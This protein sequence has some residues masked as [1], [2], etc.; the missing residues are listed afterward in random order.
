VYT[1][2]AQLTFHPGSTY[3]LETFGIN[4]Q[5]SGFLP[6]LGKLVISPCWLIQ[7]GN[8]PGLSELS[9]ERKSTSPG[10]KPSALET[11]DRGEFPR[12]GIIL[13]GKFNRWI[14]HELKQHD[15]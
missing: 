2:E 10:I 7:D 9:P 4:L 6:E 1:N 15:R 13:D 3:R 11:I 14:D 12:I 8:A 5:D